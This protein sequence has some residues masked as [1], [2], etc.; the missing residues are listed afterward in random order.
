LLCCTAALS[1]RGLRL[2]LRLLLRL[3]LFCLPALL[4]FQLRLRLLL[5]LPLHCLG[6]SLSHG[7]QLCGHLLA[8]LL[9]CRDLFPCLKAPEA[10]L[11]L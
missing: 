2:R 11:D 7:L 1:V 8:L 3:Q 10:G 6:L 9:E 4:L 5:L